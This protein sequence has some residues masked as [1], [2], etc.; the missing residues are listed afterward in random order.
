L[1]RKAKLI[2][3]FYA[4]SGYKLEMRT[5]C[6]RHLEIANPKLSEIFMATPLLVFQDI[7]SN[8]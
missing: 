6:G 8:A 2:D 5:K 7:N 3:L 1:G 4:P